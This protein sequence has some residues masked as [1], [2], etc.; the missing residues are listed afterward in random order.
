MIHRQ[1]DG[2][3]TVDAEDVEGATEK[4]LQSGNHQNG[5]YVVKKLNGCQNW[6]KNLSE[7]H[8]SSL[9]FLLHCWILQSEGKSHTM[10]S[11]MTEGQDKQ[12]LDQ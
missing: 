10:F 5:N 6:Y 2:F 4:E 9:T 3:L 7:E 12:L 1:A 8:V 11:H